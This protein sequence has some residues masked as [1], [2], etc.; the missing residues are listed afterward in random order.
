MRREDFGLDSPGRLVKVSFPDVDWAFVPDPLP[1]DWSF[2]ADLWPLL[3]EAKQEVA[4][5][6]GAGLHMPAPD[7]LLRP[8]QKREALRS[9]SLEGTYATPQQLLLYE[10]APKEPKDTSDPVSAWQEVFNYSKALEL[11][12]DLLKE[13]PLSL[14]LIRNLHGSL[15]QGVRGRSKA[16]GEFRRTQ[17]VIG[18]DRRFIPPPV[19]EMTTALDRLEKYIH[20]DGNYDPLVRCFLVHYQFETIH[21]FLDGNGRVGRLLLSLMIAD[22][23]KLA[24]PWLYLSEFF[25]RHKDEYIDTLYAVSARGDWT[26]WIRLCLRATVAQSKSAIARLSSLIELRRKYM[27]LL[28]EG[29]GAIRLTRLVD[30]LFAAPIVRTASWKKTQGISYPTAKSDV[31]KLLSLGIIQE[32][33]NMYPK[34]YIAPEIYRIAYEV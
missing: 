24:L 23:C 14:R 22:S 15:L 5:L 28:G 1:P 13:L 17:V 12:Q 2:P 26:S 19:P 33:P 27:Q 20:A 7:L 4:R 29:S 21:P 16:P 31:S 18:S 3:A 30:Q 32:V 11:G 10:L 34:T 6:D 25:E 9:S 8:L